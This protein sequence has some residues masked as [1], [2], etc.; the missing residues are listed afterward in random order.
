MLER[1]KRCR[2]EYAVIV[3]LIVIIVLL[4]VAYMQFGRRFNLLAQEYTAAQEIINE[5]LIAAYEPPGEDIQ[6]EPDDV[7]EED[8]ADDI[9]S[10]VF[11]HIL[12]VAPERLREFFDEDVNFD[13][14]ENFVMLSNDRVLISGQ[15]VCSRTEI[16]YTLEAIFGF[17]FWND[18]TNVYILS[19]APF[20]WD[21]RS[22]WWSPNRHSWVRHHELETVPI[23]FYWV[24]G[25]WPENGYDVAY[26]NGEN[27]AEELAYFTLQYL[28]RR[29]VDAWF[30]DR[31]LY[32]NLHHREPMAMS[33]GTFG[34]MVMYSTLVASMASVPGID[35][36]VILVDGQREA[37]IGGHGLPFRDIY[38]TNDLTLASLWGW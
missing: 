11:Q 21:W 13:S 22:P 5:M 7:S 16:H 34:E 14:P 28:G 33:S 10:H 32:V 20:G 9:Y 17:W 8:P 36:L 24:G 1:I 25:D 2:V 35:V 6:A 26:L 15:W 23:R 31:I 4:A 12:D 37:T 29:I 38:F 27:F 18:E 3:T 19:Y 30:V